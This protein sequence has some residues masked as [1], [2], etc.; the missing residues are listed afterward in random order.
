VLEGRLPAPIEAVEILGFGQKSRIKGL[1]D[2]YLSIQAEDG[3][4]DQ[5]AVELRVLN[6]EGFE[7]P[8]F[9]N[10]TETYLD[11]LNQGGQCQAL[12]SVISITF[13][14]F[15]V[16]GG[17]D[18]PVS[19]FQLLRERTPTIC[20][21]DVTHFVL[22]LP[23]IAEEVN[24]SS[25]LLDKWLFFLKYAGSLK[26][27]PESLKREAPIQ[28]AF[29]IAD[30]ALLSW[31]ELDDQERCEIFIQDRRGAFS[32]ATKTGFE[33]GFK[34]G[35]E[36]SKKQGKRSIRVTIAKNLLDILDDETIAQNTGLSVEQVR[37]LR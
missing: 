9:Y 18:E 20:S 13:T 32:L 33:E 26:E 16:F 7:K 34:I 2:P 22:E 30:K 5:I 29:Q 1:K 17:S 31:E 19:S 4:G 8:E 14:E 37:D 12:A 11:Q 36:E 3:S 6:V 25:T 15:I 35:F 10:V 21:E 24:Q 23:K 27:I 28:Q